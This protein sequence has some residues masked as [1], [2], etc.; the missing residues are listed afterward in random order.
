MFVTTFVW[1]GTFLA[2]GQEIMVDGNLGD[3]RSEKGHEEFLQAG[4]ERD[5]SVICWVFQ[6]AFF[7]NKDCGGF[8]PMLWDSLG[9]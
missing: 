5:R 3:S 6:R 1:V 9:E 4:K 7:G 2:W 8:V